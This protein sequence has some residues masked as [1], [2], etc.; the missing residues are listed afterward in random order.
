MRLS[1]CMRA[2]PE[3]NPSQA[4]ALQGKLRFVNPGLKYRIVQSQGP[5]GDVDADPATTF[6]SG[7]RVRFAFAS[8]IEGYLYVVQRGSSGQ[9]TLLF[10]DPEANGGR[11]TIRRAEDYVV[12]NN[13]WFA[14]DDTPGTE[15]VFVVLSR[16]PLDTLPGFDGPVNRREKVETSIVASLQR[17]I[18][19]RDLVFEKDRPA[20]IG[21]RTSQATYV[22][23][24]DE[25]AS[26]VAAFIP[27]THAK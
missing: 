23:N 3:A 13:G 5:N 15:E 20:V 8:N 24:R 6:H 9:W 19:S 17:S 25:L 11:N 4:T 21:G 22:V 16:Q 7:D 1:R 18:Q 26:R 14:F 12:P 10:P 2:R 27:L